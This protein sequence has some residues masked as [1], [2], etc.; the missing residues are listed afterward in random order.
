MKN[1]PA[2]PVN[3]MAE[4][5]GQAYEALQD[6]RRELQEDPGASDELI[7]I[8][9]GNILVYMSRAFELGQRIGTDFSQN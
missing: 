6:L 3:Q 8:F 5:N 1:T 9:F 4:L 7:D 2:P